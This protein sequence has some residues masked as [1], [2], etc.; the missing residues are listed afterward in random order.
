[1]SVIAFVIA[2][3]SLHKN[4]SARSPYWY[5]AYTTGDGKRHFRSTKTTDK[6]A[7]WQ[8]CNAWVKSSA[9]GNKLTPDK[10]REIIA[11]G[12]AD[13][14]MAT[15]QTLPT[16][17]I[18]DWFGRWLEHKEL[19]N[20]PRT[21]ERY[22]TFVKRFL[23]FLGDKADKDLSALT[24]DDVLR[25]RDQSAKKLSAGSANLNLKI[26]RSCLH[27]AV[28]QSLIDKNVASCVNSLKQNATTTRRAFT[29][30]EVRKIVKACEEA[31]GEW[32]G[33]VLTALYTGQRLG[34][35]A[36]LTWSQIDLSKRH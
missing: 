35:V 15:G 32:L 33:L 26:L 21:H 30:A 24:V 6:K 12:V 22:E 8:I 19:E 13:V 23:A 18:R 16:A 3:A 17:T 4:P 28:K 7:A 11:S 1:M 20:K 27:A 36:R 10:A 31:G 2:M 5:C 14:L 29:L 34:D 25:F 9:L